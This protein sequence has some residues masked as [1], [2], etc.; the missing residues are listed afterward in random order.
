MMLA[1]ALAAD[2]EGRTQDAASAYEATL[3]SEPLDLTA[4]LNLTV[5]YWHATDYGVSATEHLSR[6]FVALA[7]SRFR[8]LLKVAQVRFPERPEV[9]FWTKYIGWAELGEA[10]EPEECR[11]LL[12]DHPEYLEPALVLFARSAGVEAE[13]EAMQLLARCSKEG[14][15][16]CRY[17]VSVINGVLKR[18][19]PRKSGPPGV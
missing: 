3:L 18:R 14:T 6:E 7:G 2:R 10:F 8:E 5:L 13:A 4:I 19:R 12:A 11:S 15:A 17:I 1:E 16:R 9:L